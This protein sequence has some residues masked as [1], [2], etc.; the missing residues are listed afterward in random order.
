MWAAFYEV[1]SGYVYCLLSDSVFLI[2]ISPFTGPISI[3][4]FSLMSGFYRISNVFV[5]NINWNKYSPGLHVR[6]L[7]YF[8]DI[9]KITSWNMVW[10]LLDCY[11][12]ADDHGQ[13]NLF[14]LWICQ[15]FKYQP[16]IS[17]RFS[18]RVFLIRFLWGSYIRFFTWALSDSCGVSIEY[19]LITDQPMENGLLVWFGFL[20]DVYY[21]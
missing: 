17:K 12:M 21:R 13:Y 18:V 4:L 1:P 16:W 5:W 15:I 2:F 20:L 9:L 8:Q 10:F 14:F 3:G 6:F 11:Q 19:L 7:L